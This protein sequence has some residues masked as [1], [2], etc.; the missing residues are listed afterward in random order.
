LGGNICDIPGLTVGFVEDTKK[1]TGVTVLLCPEGAVGGIDLRGSAT[2]TRQVDSLRPDHLVSAIHAV[3]FAGGSAFGLDCAAGVMQY[4][5]EKGAGL[6]VLY[7]MVPVVPTAV[8]FD[9]ALGDPEAFPTAAMAYEACTKAGKTFLPGSHGAG[10]GTSVGKALG[11]DHAMKGGQGSALESGADGLLVGALTITNAFGDILD[12]A[13]QKIIAGARSDSAPD[14]F[15]DAFQVFANG[16]S[17]SDKFARQSQNTVL[18]VVATNADFDKPTMTRI[19]KMAHA[20]LARVVSPCHAAFDGDVCIALS[21]GQKKAS[22]NTVGA[23]AAKALENATLN[24]IRHADG[25]GLLPDATGYKPPASE[26]P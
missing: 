19:A 14:G 10:C 6:N 3:C 15:A 4:L 20:G 24:A 12:P 8:V 13:A 26:K 2:G 7:R 23:L 25:F 21:L 22:E 16:Q 17:P 9:C 18:T 1:M 11:I 5:A